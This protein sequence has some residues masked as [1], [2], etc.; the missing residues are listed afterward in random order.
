MGGIAPDAWDQ[1]KAS[2]KKGRLDFDQ[3]FTQSY[4]HVE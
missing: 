3:L 4:Q 2:G 1:Y